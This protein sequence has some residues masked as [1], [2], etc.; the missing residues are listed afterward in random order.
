M[1]TQYLPPVVLSTL[2]ICSSAL[3]HA[4]PPLHAQTPLSA[5][6]LQAIAKQRLEP[7]KRSFKQLTISIT[8]NQAAAATLTIQPTPYPNVFFSTI[9]QDTSKHSGRALLYVFDAELHSELEVGQSG[10]YRQHSVAPHLTGYHA[11]ATLKPKDGFDTSRY[12]SDG[13]GTAIATTQ[14]CT[15][16]NSSA[17]KQHHAKLQG[18]ALNMSCSQDRQDALRLVWLQDYHL[19]LPLRSPSSTE[20]NDMPFVIT[21]IQE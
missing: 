12:Q 13:N 2:A 11:L 20:S 10:V 3:V 14:H 1:Y 7:P 5:E 4:E 21:D 18:L 17:A 19:L 9:R 8:H 16:T 15:V 6:V